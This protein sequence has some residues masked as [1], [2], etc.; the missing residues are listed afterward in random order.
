MQHTFSNGD[1]VKYERSHFWS[2]LVC[3]F[4]AIT[5]LDISW[6]TVIGPTPPGTGVIWDATLEASSNLTSPTRR[7]PF[8]E[9]IRNRQRN[10]TFGTH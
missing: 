10:I 3:L 8:Y 4:A 1:N 5:T 9:K 7:Y 6:A 2:N